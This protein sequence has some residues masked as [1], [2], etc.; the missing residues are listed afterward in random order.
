[1]IVDAFEKKLPEAFLATKAALFAIGETVGIVI[2]EFKLLF[3]FINDILILK[4]LEAIKNIDLESFANIVFGNA[5]T[6]ATA[7]A[8]G[9]MQSNQVVNLNAPISVSVPPGTPSALIGESIT[10]GIERALG[11]KI[12]QASRA[13]EPV[14][15]F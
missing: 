10:E 1:M 13:T 15:E 11:D 4:P 6:P 2:D 3:G 7:P 9:G 5:P 12:R 8:G 14:T